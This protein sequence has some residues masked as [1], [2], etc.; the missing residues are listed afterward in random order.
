MKVYVNDR[1]VYLTPGMKVR[2]ALVAVGLLDEVKRGKKIYDDLGQEIG[3]DGA[4]TEG[5]K[6]RCIRSKDISTSLSVSLKI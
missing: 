5:D 1:E 2:H 4:L 3:L 6:I